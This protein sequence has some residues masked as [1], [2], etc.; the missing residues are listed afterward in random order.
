ML[1]YLVGDRDNDDSA[2]VLFDALQL[3]QK[4]DLDVWIAGDDH[5]DRVGNTRA[6]SVLG[7]VHFLRRP[8][9]CPG[10]VGVAVAGRNATDAV[11]H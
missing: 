8:S 10:H 2:A 11:E 7:V 6:V 5:H 1:P 4:I 9:K 3:D